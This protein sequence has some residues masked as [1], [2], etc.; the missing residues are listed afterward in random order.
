MIVVLALTVAVLY[1]VGAY[2]ILQ[3]SLSGIVIG[4][5]VMGHGANLMLLGA[6]GRAGTPPFAG[7]DPAAAADPLPQ[8]LALTAIVIT[9]GLSGL[10]LALAYRSWLQR[11]DDM[12]EDD[13]EDRR[14]ASAQDRLEADREHRE[15]RELAQSE[16]RGDAPRGGTT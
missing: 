2:L 11:H 3:R 16:R 9:F 14:I 6:G 4:L 13:L 7:A 12:V 10:L 1:G 8:A 5:A 15:A